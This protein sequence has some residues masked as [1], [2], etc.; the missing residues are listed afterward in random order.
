[1]MESAGAEKMN[2]AA[3]YISG[4][5]LKIIN[6]DW[7]RE[8]QVQG[9]FIAS[10]NGPTHFTDESLFLNCALEAGVEYGVRISTTTSN[11]DPSTTVFY[12]RN[13]G[14][15]E[16]MLSQPE[17]SA[18]NGTSLEPN[19]FSLMVTPIVQDGLEKYRETGQKD[20]F[21]L[22]IDGDNG[23]A[24]IDAHE[25]GVIAAHLLALEDTSPH[26]SKKYVLIRPSNASGMQIVKPLEKHAGTTV[27]KVVFRDVF[28]DRKYGIG[29]HPGEHTAFTRFGPAKRI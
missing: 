17:F 11:V 15:I 13:H 25:V 29:W 27:D 9:L 28:L 2:L 8:H 24:I 7:L 3:P 6:A 23:F 18:M 10:H 26:N 21:K 1:M 5:G 19:V 12:G 16:A 20:P 22:M 14:G 4:V